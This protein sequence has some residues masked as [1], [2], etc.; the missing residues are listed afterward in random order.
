MW[1]CRIYYKNPDKTFYNLAKFY[2][3]FSGSEQECNN[4]IQAEI[5][6]MK[7]EGKS[8]CCSVSKRKVG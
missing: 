6:R 8:Y 2:S 7:K 5:S 4:F 3:E 1:N